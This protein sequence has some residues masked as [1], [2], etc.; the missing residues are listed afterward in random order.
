MKFEVLEEKSMFP[1]KPNPV[2]ELLFFFYHAF[3]SKIYVIIIHQIIFEN[4][5][6]AI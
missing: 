6:G 3:Y 5:G 1:K 2:T 4:L